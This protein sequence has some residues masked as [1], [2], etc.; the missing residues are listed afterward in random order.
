MSLILKAQLKDEIDSWVIKVNKKIAEGNGF[1]GN[2]AEPTA[3]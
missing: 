3:E 1:S 2:D